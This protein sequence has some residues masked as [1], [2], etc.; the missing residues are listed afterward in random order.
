VE[1]PLLQ[2]III[3]CGLAIGVIFACHRLGIPSIVGLLLTG[4]LAGPY[5]LGIIGQSKEVEHLAEIGVV[6]L[7]FTIGLEFSLKSLLKIKFMSLVGGGLQVL[8]TVGA[9]ALLAHGFGLPFN[10]A[11]FCGFLVS[12][13][14]TAIVL[15]ILQERAEMESPHGRLTVG[16]LLFQDIAVVPMMLLAPILAGGDSNVGWTLLMLVAKAAAVIILVVVS[17][18]WIVPSVLYQIARLRARELFILGIVFVGLGVAWATAEVGLSLALGAF[19]AGLIVSESEYSHRALGNVIPFRDLFTSFFFVSV[20]M[21][22]DLRFVAGHAGLLAVAAACAVALKCLTAGSAATLLGLPLRTS[23]LTGLGLAHIGEFSFVLSETGVRLG[24]IDGNLYQLFLGVSVLTMIATPFFISG[25]DRLA[26][27]VLK[28]PWPE[29]LRSGLR[30]VKEIAGE[31]PLKDHLVIVGFGLNGRNLSRAAVAAGI[32]RIIVELNPETVRKEQ[33]R[34]EPIFYGD[35]SQEAV[36]KHAAVKQARVMVIVIS[37]PVAARRIVDAAR[38]LNPKLHIVAR[39]RFVTEME[40]L[41]ELG[42]DEVIPE[43]YE[44]SV[45]MLVRVLTKYLVPKNDIERFVFKFRADHYDMLRALTYTPPTMSDFSMHIPEVEIA[46]VRV[47]PDSA[48]AGKTLAESGLRTRHGVTVLAIRTNSN[49]VANPSG[50]DRIQADQVLIVLGTPEK[51]GE[52]SEV[53]IG[54]CDSE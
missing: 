12:L 5:G 36:L 4:V 33:E 37:D 27:Q 54:S 43:D 16:I 1:I 30:P 7:L 25:G 48:L 9:A 24:L 29:R 31:T 10:Q 2:D 20:G 34:G 38:K 6:C 23:L 21:L 35:A 17:A 3:I 49:V 45:E 51:I 26:T 28:L 53:L 50:K 46:S 11:L 44:A 8:L 15:R 22:L 32:P 41:Y 14:S 40:P 19:L 39:T 18:K 42:A 52:V 47:C 13:S